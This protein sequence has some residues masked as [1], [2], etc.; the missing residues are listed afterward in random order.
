MDFLRRISE[1]HAQPAQ[2]VLRNC[3]FV[4]SFTLSAPSSTLSAVLFA[5]FLAPF[6][7]F[8]PVF[9]AAFLVS[10]AASL[11]SSFWAKSAV[12]ASSAA[13]VRVR[14]CFISRLDVATPGV[15]R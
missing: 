8:L 10:F 9:F 6:S 13:T 4:L 12:E 5:A 15:F 14:N 1:T 11:I 7:I 2:S 3:Y